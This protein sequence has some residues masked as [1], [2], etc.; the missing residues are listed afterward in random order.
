MDYSLVVIVTFIMSPIGTIRALIGVLWIF[1]AFASSMSLSSS[2]GPLKVVILYT[3]AWLQDGGCYI[4]G[5]LVGRTKLAPAISPG[6]TV[7]GAIGGLLFSLGVTFLLS[8]VYHDIGRS[9][10]L[11]LSI[12]TGIVGIPG[13]LSESY[14]KR[15]CGVKDTG[16][17]L[18]AA[19]GVLD[20]W[21][22]LLFA[23]PFAHAYI[24]LMP[25]WHV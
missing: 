9:D 4:V 21:D 6:K 23:I 14:F 3:V 1:P 2:E 8:F 20:R 11:I 15:R 16:R 24:F 5:K 12:L 19:G 22:S 10:L 25:L 13:D 18:G 7:E 17:L